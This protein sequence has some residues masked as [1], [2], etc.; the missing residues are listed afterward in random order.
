MSWEC[1]LGSVERDRGMTRELARSDERLNGLFP[2]RR[3]PIKAEITERREHF[4]GG[5]LPRDAL[6]RTRNVRNRTVR[7]AELLHAPK[8]VE[9]PDPLRRVRDVARAQRR[10]GR[11]DLEFPHAGQYEWRELA[12]DLGHRGHLPTQLQARD[13][14]PET[15]FRRTRPWCFSRAQRRILLPLPLSPVRPRSRS[16]F[17]SRERKKDAVFV[18]NEFGFARGDRLCDRAGD[19]L[20]KVRN[21][22]ERRGLVE[23]RDVSLCEKWGVPYPCHE[24]L[25]E[26]ARAAEFEARQCGEGDDA[27]YRGQGGRIIGSC[28]DRRPG[29]GW[30]GELDA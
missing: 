8:H 19:K 5:A 21:F 3:K 29:G 10:D 2:P 16:V 18:E 13:V 27:P 9:E 20:G 26:L 14:Q 28:V 23:E 24:L 17:Q 22:E 7:H 12:T 25:Q 6:Q 1:Y 11:D 15:L 4:R 30:G